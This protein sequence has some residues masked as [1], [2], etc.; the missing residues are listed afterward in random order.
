MGATPV[1]G[2]ALVQELSDGRS[3]REALA[4][5]LFDDA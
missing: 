2:S 5:R 1:I 3:L 4:L